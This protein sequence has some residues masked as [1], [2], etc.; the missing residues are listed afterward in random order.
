[1]KRKIAKIFAAVLVMALCLGIGA[2]AST[3]SEII[4]ALLNKD[5]TITYRGQEQT[6]ADAAGNQVFPISYEGSTYLPV[7]AI[8]DML[9]LIIEWDEE[10][11]AVHI[12][13]SDEPD[14][15]LL[16]ITYDGRIVVD[17]TTGVGEMIPLRVRLEPAGTELNEE[18]I[19]TSSD[20]N[21]FT[22]TADNTEGSSATVNA[23][24]PGTATL[25]VSSGG[26]EAECIIRVAR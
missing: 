9:D 20:V 2:Y 19:W 22:V 26:V 21:V 24:R 18:I 10:E 6:M 1:M 7:R 13:V 23:I 14:I 17:I 12:N 5:L 3:N 15:F 11:N 4:Q 25:T 8:S 16:V